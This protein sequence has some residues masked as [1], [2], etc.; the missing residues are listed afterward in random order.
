MSA[1]QQPDQRAR[2]EPLAR[3]FVLLPPAYP[4]YR[5]PLSGVR[6]DLVHALLAHG[7]WV[8]ALIQ[9]LVQRVDA[10]PVTIVQE[11]HP[12]RVSRT[13]VLAR[14]LA[15]VGGVANHKEDRGEEAR[16][17]RALA[18]EF[19]VSY[20][21]MLFV[22]VR[23]VTRRASVSHGMESRLALEAGRELGRLKEEVTVM[24]GKEPDDQT[25]GSV[26]EQ[27]ERLAREGWEWWKIRERG[28]IQSA[29]A[30]GEMGEGID[31]LVNSTTN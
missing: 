29:G 27:M 28:R 24:G 15:Q 7:R 21:L 22:L 5:P 1:A 26:W 6:T 19:E 13:W 25:I 31:I 4:A 9:S 23:D 3:A 30:S 16:A 18:E 10:D 8:P 14:L 20:P 11:N 17:A 2:L 12:V